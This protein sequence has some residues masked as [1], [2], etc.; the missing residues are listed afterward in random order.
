MLTLKVA[1]SKYWLLLTKINLTL[2]Y[3]NRQTITVH[4]WPKL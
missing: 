3:Q 2:Q 4:I 1:T